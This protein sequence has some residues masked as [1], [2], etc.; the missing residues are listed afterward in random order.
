VSEVVGGF[1]SGEVA[2]KR[3]DAAA[4]PRNCPL[5]RLAQAGLQPAEGHLDRVQVGG[6]FGQIAKRRTSRFD[7]LTAF[8]ETFRWIEERGIFETG[9][10]SRS[11]EG[12]IAVAAVVE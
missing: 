2:G 10:G 12:S 3:A 4:Q 1:A 6:I 7:R 11:Y 9:L 5:T 8:D